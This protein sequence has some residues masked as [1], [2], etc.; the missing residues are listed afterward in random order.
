MA[1]HISQLGRS[2]SKNEDHPRACRATTRL[3][4][5]AGQATLADLE[6]SDTCVDCDPNGAFDRGSGHE[7]G[8][9]RDDSEE[10]HFGGFSEL[11]GAKFWEKMPCWFLGLERGN[12]GFR[13]EAE[14]ESDDQETQYILEEYSGAI[15]LIWDSPFWP[16]LR[17]FVYVKTLWNSLRV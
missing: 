12:E 13:T 3:K 10:L 14:L 17:R 6:I 11:R 2:A 15:Y 5:V 4:L 16:H 8:A 7:G 9:E 1:Y